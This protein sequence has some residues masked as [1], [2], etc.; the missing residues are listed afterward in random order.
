MLI[1][2]KPVKK[3]STTL[4]FLKFNILNA[5]PLASSINDRL[6]KYKTIKQK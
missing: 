5:T 2:S 3:Y 6:Q 1:I 4:D